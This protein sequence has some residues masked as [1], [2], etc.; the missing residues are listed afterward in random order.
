MKTIETEMLRLRQRGIYISLECGPTA[1]T[2]RISTMKLRC[3]IL[4]TDDDP[5]LCMEEAEREYDK[6]IA[7]PQWRHVP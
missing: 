6:K 7:D 5:V 4:T 3:M 1:Y 2:C